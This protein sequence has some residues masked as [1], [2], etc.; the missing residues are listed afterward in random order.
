[1]QIELYDNVTVRDNVLIIGDKGSGKT[2]F[3][4][5]IIKNALEA[6]NRLRPDVLVM[7]NRMNEY[8]KVPNLTIATDEE[9]IIR[10]INDTVKPHVDGTIRTPLLIVIDPLYWAEMKMRDT[11][12]YGPFMKD[13][14]HNGTKYG[15]TIF[16]IASDSFHVHKSIIDGSSLKIRCRDAG[17]GLYSAREM[18]RPEVDSTFNK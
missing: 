2:T 11:D 18:S 6:D 12:W 15:V 8:R 9:S 10:A 5:N 13:L 4:K 17:S 1:M 14:Y 3:V 16:T 7:T